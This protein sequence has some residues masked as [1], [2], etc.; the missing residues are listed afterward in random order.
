M[1]VIAT[2]YFLALVSGLVILL[3]SLVKDLFA[4]RIGPNLKR[5]WL[6]A[7]NV[8]GLGSFPFHVVMALT[9]AVFAFHD[10]I[11][12][13]QNRM[14]H[15]GQLAAT[16]QGRA[17]PADAKPR[18]PATMLPPEEIVTRVTAIAPTFEPTMLQYVQATGP[19]AIVRVWGHD[20]RALEH[21]ALGGFAMVDPYS[22]RL[23][24]TDYLPGRQGAAATVLTSI[25]ALHF[26]TY[27]GTPVKWM[28][29]LLALL[30][31]W[32]FYGGNLLWIESLRRKAKKR[33][34]NG[35]IPLQRRDTRLMA[36][37]TVGVCLGAVCGISL[38][39]VA[40]KWLHGHV[41]DLNGWHRVV[42]YV[43]FFAALGW[44]FFRGGARASVDLL[45]MAAAS[46][47]AIPVTT[48]LAALFPSSGMWAHM[49]PD[50]LGVD[51]TALAMSLAFAWM[52]RSAAR[53]VYE[54]PA[55]SVW[56]ARAPE[57]VDSAET[58]DT[59]VDGELDGELAE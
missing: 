15:E 36:S 18:D 1:G 28:Y 22:G 12:F 2:L 57:A 31:A 35:A 48:V 16:F 42:Y 17:A 38:T 54:G 55:D 40:A 56:S 23:V 6:D 50:A 25:F 11:Y 26:G 46:T 29:F 58:P 21:R 13:V 51:A 34:A 39:I 41:A 27:G 9:A 10:G 49:T 33:V 19:R 3:P 59:A 7:H 47:L 24:S 8:V 32:L 44:S 30:G 4:L 43:T 52:A 14:I 45:R 37:A 20:A 53:R 5:M